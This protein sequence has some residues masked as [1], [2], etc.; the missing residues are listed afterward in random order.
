M[1]WLATA[2]VAISAATAHAQ[3][4]QTTPNAPPSQPYG[5]HAPAPQPPPTQPG[6]YAG[7]YTPAPVPGPYAPAPGPYAP[8]PYAPGPYAPA[9][10]P[11]T[12]I[13][14][15]PEEDELLRRGEISMGAHVGGSLLNFYFGFGLGQAVQGRW[16]DT[17][18]IFTVGEAASLVAIMVAF[19]RSVGP[20]FEGDCMRDGEQL[21]IIGVIGLL[22]FHL[23]GVA[24]ALI[25]P[26]SHNR[27]VRELRA[28]LGMMSQAPRVIPYVAPTRAGGGGGVAGLSF[29][30]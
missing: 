21:L 29:A 23:G 16:R 11:P 3:P 22:G 28:R 18:W 19:S 15:T 7:P 12:P 10:M 1:T 24:D 26:P 27:K 13:T 30:F 5:P 2:A 8:G 25:G 6:P 20:C 14:I 4:G 17:G 9:P